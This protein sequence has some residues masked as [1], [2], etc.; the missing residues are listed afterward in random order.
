MLSRA[1]LRLAVDDDA[2]QLF[3]SLPFAQ[4]DRLE[5]N[6]GQAGGVPEQPGAKSRVVMEQATAGPQ[7]R[8]ALKIKAQRERNR[9]GIKANLVVHMPVYILSHELSS[10]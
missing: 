4:L 1:W 3:P 6:G 7:V 8:F 5:V 9:A 2:I 10:Y